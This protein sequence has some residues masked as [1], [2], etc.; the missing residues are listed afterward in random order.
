MKFDI[1]EDIK[2][3]PVD[4]PTFDWMAWELKKL[5]VKKHPLGFGVG[6]R[7][8]KD[9]RIKWEERL[10]IFNKTASK[11]MSLKTDPQPGPQHYSLINHWP[12]KVNKN[13][14]I[15]KEEGHN[16]LKHI[17]KGVVINPYY[18]KIA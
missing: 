12:G 4:I 18:R 14:K 6:D 9:E 1:N 2:P 5:N 17:T 3:I 7:F 13:I 11:P 8:Q 15:K 16:Y 10:K